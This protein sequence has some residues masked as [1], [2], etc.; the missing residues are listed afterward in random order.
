MNR[1]SRAVYASAAAPGASPRPRGG[2]ATAKRVREAAMTLPASWV[3]QGNT[4]PLRAVRGSRRGW[5]REAKGG[6]PAEI[7]VTTDPGNPLHEYCHHLQPAMPA[8]HRLFVDLHR[9]RTAGEPRVR[10]GP[11]AREL[12]REDQYLR[13]YS[14]REYGPGQDPLEVFTMAVQQIFHPVWKVDYLRDLV[15][16]DPE[17][18]DLV[19]GV[20]LH[21]DP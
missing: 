17:M 3:R 11:T 12:G 10:V 15:R 7:S 19:T 14:G 4:L 20:L 21:Y 16:D 13:P 2:G 5:Y 9:R 6:R 8:L 1:I 18:L